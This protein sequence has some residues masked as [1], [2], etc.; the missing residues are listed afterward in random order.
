MTM[1]KE[2]GKIVTVIFDR[3]LKTSV[4]EYDGKYPS[5]SIVERFGG[6]NAKTF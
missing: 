6:E 3:K 4:V 1:I 5:V 2:Y